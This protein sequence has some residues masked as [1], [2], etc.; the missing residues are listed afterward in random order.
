MVSSPTLTPNPVYDGDGDIN[1]LVGTDILQVGEV[2]TLSVTFTFTPSVYFGPFDN[3]ATVIGV[4]SVGSAVEDADGDGFSLALDATTPITLGWFKASEL[5]VGEVLFEWIT[6]AE[7]ANAGFYLWSEDADGNWSQINQEMIA[8]QGDSLSS[9]HYQYLA[10]SVSGNIFT[11]TDVSVMG[12]EVTRGP[13][14]LNETYGSQTQRKVTDWESIQRESEQKQRLRKQKRQQ[15][16]EQQLE[17]LQGMHTAP[18][19]SSVARQ[20]QSRSGLLSLVSEALGFVMSALIAPAEAVELVNLEVESAGIYR[21]SHA[22]LVGAGVDLSGMSVGRIGLKEGNELVPIKLEPAGSSTFGAG[23]SLEFT[24]RGMDTLYTGVNKYTL[25][26]DE[27]QSLIMDDTRVIPDGPVAYSYLAEQ[28]YAPQNTY[29]QHSPDLEDSWYADRLTAITSPAEKT[30]VLTVDDHA[31]VFSSPNSSGGPGQIAAQKVALD[32]ELWGGSALPGNG[33]TNPDHHVLIEVNGVQVVDDRFD[34]LRVREIYQPLGQI[35]DGNNSIKVA[36]PRD[37]GYPF[38]IINIDRISLSYPRRFNAEEAGTS[39]VFDSSWNKFRVRQLIA[40][41]ATVYRV[42]TTGEAYE[43]LVQDGQCYG[44]SVGCLLTFAGDDTGADSTY[45]VATAGGIKQ[46]T[47]SLA[48]GYE[49]LFSGP[50]SHLLIAHPDFINTA[51]QSLEQYEADLAGINGSTEIVNVEAIYAQYSGH[52][53]DANAIHAY[54][55]DAYA[56]RGTRQV[57]LVGGD[58]YDYR[59]HLQTGA[60]SF[61][62]SLYVQIALNMNAV[63]SD[64]KYGDIDGD[65]IPDIEVTRLPVRKESELVTLLAKRQ[66]YIGRS[67]HQDVVIAADATDG[68][69]YVFKGDAEGFA[70]HFTGWDIDR[71]YLDDLGGAWGQAGID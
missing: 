27:G 49:E 45:F 35:I 69:G 71:A 26:L 33:V 40:D 3:T 37:H 6:E 2:A 4:P 14:E 42:S 67:Y 63:P 64:A 61:V 58:M 21:V 5:G 12:E 62:P 50:A 18:D 10:T 29:T 31:P 48:P 30:V 43:M 47:I 57:T 53:L 28:S 24:G 54:I 39:L 70:Q 23:S 44:G 56:Q 7:V 25:V 36:V 55:Q 65:D 17:Q 60:K 51:G 8:S 20:S 59:D 13:F 32:V 1:M 38:D 41:S 19:S 11:I 22:D 68:S 15:E 34:G 9:Q 16:L 66:N 52:V 46:P